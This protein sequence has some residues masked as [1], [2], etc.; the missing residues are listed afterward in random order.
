MLRP[1]NRCS[2]RRRYHVDTAAVRCCVLFLIVLGSCSDLGDPEVLLPQIVISTTQIDYATV[3]IG[4]PQ[5][6]HLQI[7][8]R[9]EGELHGELSLLQDDTAFIVQPSGQFLLLP[10]DTLAVELI[11]TPAAALNYS[12]QIVISS[13]DP[14]NPEHLITLTGEGTALPVPALT[15]SNSS[16]NFGTILTGSSSHQQ[17][18]LSSTGNDTLLISSIDFDRGEYS[19]DANTPLEL[20]PG[21]SQLI[22][23][24]FQ[25]G[26]AGVF[27]GSM[28]I[29]SNSP[30]TPDVVSLIG[31]AEAPVSYAGSVQPV[32]NSSC[33]GCHGSNGGL[34]L[35]S[36]TTLMA[37]SNSGPTV[38]IG[39]GPNSLLIRR[40]RGEV[41]TRMPQN[42]PALP[43][44]TIGNIETWIN[45]GA[46]DN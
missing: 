3:T 11:F 46:L 40:L 17:I 1:S 34:N 15:V 2:R 12:G 42:G 32:W 5:A 45:Q 41:G 39:D 37:G 23:I 13:D 22:T 21:A 20:N 29:I 16:L 6:R 30:S 43:D 33:G 10:G 25:S 9:G 18:T 7:V 8:N 28:T 44:E 19:I 35:S 27:D 24:S 31:E 4:S 36:Y 26:V 38:T 14:E